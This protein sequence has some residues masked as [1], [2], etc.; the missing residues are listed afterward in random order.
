MTLAR[1]TN[2]THSPGC[3]GCPACSELA[4]AILA[5]P[6][7]PVLREA[8]G[9]P[10]LRALAERELRTAVPQN[11]VTAAEDYTPRDPYE[12]YLSTLRAAAPTPESKANDDYK[13]AR[14]LE[15]AAE[16]TELDAHIAATPQARMTAAE[17]A[18]YEPVDSYAEGIKALQ[19]Q[20]LKEAR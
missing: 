8:M 7:N 1:F 10:R 17:L 2:G 11:T 13:I 14:T 6:T 4:A 15:L 18:E 12:P 19:A 9:R 16:A 5:N 3:S 20:A